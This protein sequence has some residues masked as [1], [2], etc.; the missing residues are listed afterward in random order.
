MGGLDLNVPVRGQP[1]CSDSQASQAETSVDLGSKD[2]YARRSGGG[3]GARLFQLI[4]LRLLDARESAAGFL[5]SSSA[6]KHFFPYPGLPYRRM[7]ADA[8]SYPGLT[9]ISD[10]KKE[11]LYSILEFTL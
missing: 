10:T 9:F 11:V 8:H 1:V 7:G 2:I 6:Y 4:S 5:L 3:E